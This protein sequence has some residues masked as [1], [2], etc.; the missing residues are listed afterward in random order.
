MISSAISG[1]PSIMKAR[2]P[3][4]VITSK[5]D[6]AAALKLFNRIL[7]K[8][9]RPEAI[10]TDQLR[11]YSA[12]MNESAADRHK[13]GPRLNNRA[14]NLHQPLR[15][16]ERAMQQFRSV[17]ALQ[18]FSSIHPQAHNHFYQERHLV[19]RQTYKQRRMGALA[20]WRTLTA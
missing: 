12:A 20:G 2:P 13:A 14:E 1:S 10:V 5:L 3:L 11:A 7:K 19:A 4:A 17:K 9:G 8:H 15:R 6:K 18:K 16:R